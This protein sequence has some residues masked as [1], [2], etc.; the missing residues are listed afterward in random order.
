MRHDKIEKARYIATGLREWRQSQQLH[1]QQRQPATTT[2]TTLPTQAT[3]LTRLE[4]KLLDSEKAVNELEEV[5]I[6]WVGSGVPVSLLRRHLDDGNDDLK[7]PGNTESAGAAV[8]D[9]GDTVLEKLLTFLMVKGGEHRKDPNMV[10][11]SQRR[12]TAAATSTTSK[13]S[14][15]QRRQS[16]LP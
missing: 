15:S 4:A 5:I 6:A 1:Q 11:K 3:L 13:R 9:N 7:Q 2:A 8:L 10:V 12:S 16:A 14:K